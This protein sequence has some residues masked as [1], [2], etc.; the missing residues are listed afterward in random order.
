MNAFLATLR[1]PLVR[2]KPQLGQRHQRVSEG[3]PFISDRVAFLVPSHLL[4]TSLTTCREP[5][6]MPINP[7]WSERK[8]DPGNLSGRG[9]QTKSL[10][11]TL[12]L[13]ALES[14]ER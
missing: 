1:D 12:A 6:S 7:E 8:V 5:R 14:S 11:E 3:T 13:L 2:V 9:C 4:S 10:H